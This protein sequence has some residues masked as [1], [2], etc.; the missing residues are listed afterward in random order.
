MLD[1]AQPIWLS[2]FS[3]KGHF[4]A[5]NS[6]TFLTTVLCLQ[7]PRRNLHDFQ[8]GPTAGQQGNLLRGIDNLTVERLI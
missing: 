6:K 2:G 8:K 1:V 5:K 3:K 4:S 7:L